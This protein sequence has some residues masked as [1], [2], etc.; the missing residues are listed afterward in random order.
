MEAEINVGLLSNL[1][2]LMSG[3]RLTEPLV[4]EIIRISFGRNLHKRVIA[5]LC[6][7]SSLKRI[8]F[9]M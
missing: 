5:K 1:V 6:T 2:V 7:L 4:F 8:V 9:R 3:N